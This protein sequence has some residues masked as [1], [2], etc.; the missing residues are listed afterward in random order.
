MKGRINLSL[1]ID[2]SQVI[3]EDSIEALQLFTGSKDKN[4]V[5]TYYMQNIARAISVI[6]ELNL[7]NVTYTIKGELE[8]SPTDISGYVLED[9]ADSTE[10]LT[11]NIEEQV[12][13]LATLITEDLEVEKANTYEKITELINDCYENKG[14]PVDIYVSPELFDLIFVEG[15]EVATKFLGCNI[16]SEELSNCLLQIAYE[17]YGA[18]KEKEFMAVESL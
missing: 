8:E 18:N 9:V 2:L 10:P 17:P 16:Y 5:A 13:D 11:D 3:C 14:I 6:S 4:G 7:P 15:E 12:G 1:D